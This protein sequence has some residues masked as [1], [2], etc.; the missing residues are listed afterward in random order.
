M[1]SRS[2]VVLPKTLFSMDVLLEPCL[3]KTH[4]NEKV[5]AGLRIDIQKKME[6]YTTQRSYG[7]CSMWSYVLQ[8]LIHRKD[9]YVTSDSVR[10]FS[11]GHEHRHIGDNLM[12]C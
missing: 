1:P 12:R 7:I 9:G 8:P 11:V 10:D 6:R 4:E 5:A 2:D 3:T